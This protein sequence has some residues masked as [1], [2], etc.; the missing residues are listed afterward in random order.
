MGVRLDK[1]ERNS[2]STMLSD[3]LIVPFLGLDVLS[4]TYADAMNALAPLTGST[5][6]LHTVQDAGATTTRRRAILF[7][8]TQVTLSIGRSQSKEN[9]PF[10]TDRI[11]TR[12]DFSRINATTGK[13]VQASTYNVTT[14][15]QS[16]DFTP[17]AMSRHAVSLA[18]F[19]ILGGLRV[20]GS[21]TRPFDEND[22]DTVLRILSGEG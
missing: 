7:D 9:A 13:P 16:G 2:P 1:I 3:P 4:I 21:G 6:T 14:L 5:L 15:P 8:G 20:D 10:V 17:F 19:A 18:L 11:Q 12:F 22:G